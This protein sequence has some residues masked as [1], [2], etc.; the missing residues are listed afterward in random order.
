MHYKHNQIIFCNIHVYTTHMYK[1]TY[2]RTY[3]KVLF[4]NNKITQNSCLVLFALK[5]SLEFVS[6][7]SQKQQF[8]R[9]QCHSAKQIF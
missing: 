8:P 1:Y 3:N 9:H 6:C 4:S 2:E 5:A 7:S